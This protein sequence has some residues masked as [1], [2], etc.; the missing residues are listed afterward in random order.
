MNR[1][2]RMLG[3]LLVA[4]MLVGLVVAGTASAKPTGEIG[5]QGATPPNV[6][7][8]QGHLLDDAGD[9][10]ADGAHEITFSMWD[11]GTGGTRLWGPETHQ[12]ETSDGFFAATLGTTDTIEV[13]ALGTD[14]YLAIEVGGETLS[15]RQQ[16][17]SVAFALSASHAEAA[18]NAERLDGEPASTYLSWSN[19]TD[20]PSGFAD[21]VDDGQQYDVGDGLDLFGTE[22]SVDASDLAGD[23]LTTFK[24]NLTLDFTAVAPDEHTHSGDDITGGVVDEAYIDSDIARDSELVT[25]TAGTGLTRTNRTFNVD[26]AGSGGA[27]TVA[28]SDHD[29]DD[30]YYTESEL[31]SSTTEAPIHRSHI[32]PTLV[33]P[34]VGSIIAW[35]KDMT[36]TP[37]LPD[38]WV[39]CN[40]QVISDTRSPYHGLAV[41]DL[42]A[43]LQDGSTSSGMFLRGGSTSG[44]RQEDATAV[45]GLSAATSGVRS[46]TLGGQGTVGD[47]DRF[48]GPS[49]S[50]AL[51]SSDGETRPA[52]MTVVWI[53]KVRQ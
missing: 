47:P 6:L 34:P 33:L 40:G 17:A 7:T 31:I 19:L 21:G 44:Q 1:R 20:V 8:Y 53:M 24:N 16:L 26:F 27:V 36:G 39:E 22:L 5:L 46:S 18:G 9:P 15:P 45:N 28:R 41:P 13:E 49:A 2:K 25:Y 38:G 11:A 48:A 52:N 30:R 35:H 43:D 14:T 51:T 50:V 10:V 32:T 3:S 37:P 12:V 4:L 23:G 29:H 42:N